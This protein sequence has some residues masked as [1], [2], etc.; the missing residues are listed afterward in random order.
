MTKNLAR[1]G[2]PKKLQPLTINGGNYHMR[3]GQMIVGTSKTQ[4]AQLDGAP[5][6]TTPRAGKS[7]AP[8]AT[9]PGMRS[10]TV[11]DD[12]RLVPRK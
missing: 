7:L 12:A 11:P 4:A 6:L 1:D 5:D 8:V 10:R 9:T 2:A 3:N